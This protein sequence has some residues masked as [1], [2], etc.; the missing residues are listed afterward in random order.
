[1]VR[2]LTEILRREKLLRAGD[3]RAAAPGGFEQLGLLHPIPSR[4]GTARHLR[5]RYT[6]DG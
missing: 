5:H 6:N 3:L 1:M 2:D 4:I